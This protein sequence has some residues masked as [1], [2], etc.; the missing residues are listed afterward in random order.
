[1]ARFFLPTALLPTGWAHDVS[2]AVADGVITAVAP[3]GSPDDATRLDGIALP[4]M[5]N[6]H[7]H[8]FQR[9]MA[10]PSAAAISGPGAR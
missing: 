2:I 6:L 8:A 1:M 3:A 4:G 5:P 7:S 10:G 9:G